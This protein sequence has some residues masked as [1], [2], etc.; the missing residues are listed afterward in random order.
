MN[1]LTLIIPAKK[2]AESL[3]TVLIEL[4]KFNYRILVLLDKTD[5]ETINAIS[6]FDIEIIYQKNKGYGDALINGIQN[7]R[8]KYFCIFNADGSFNPA[9]IEDM[10]NKIKF[11]NH[12][13]VCAS[14][15]EKNAGSDDDTIITLIGNYFFSYLC[16]LLFNINISDILYTFVIGN[17]N[18]I[19]GLDLKQK[20]FTFCVELPIK[21]KLNN[22]SIASIKSHE[23]KRIAGKKKVNEIYDGFLILIHILKLFC[24]KKFN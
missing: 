20:D 24:K 4:K 5:I 8:T 13:L 14:R 1:E 19:V 2:E 18:Q 10:H 15:Y 11:N 7:V 22:L 3:P 17:T 16:N 23:R 12:D 6:K 9:E 21:A